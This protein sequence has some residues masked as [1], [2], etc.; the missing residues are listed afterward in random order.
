[1]RLL[2]SEELAVLHRVYEEQGYFIFPSLNDLPIGTVFDRTY[3][4]NRVILPQPFAIV[5]RATAD[6]YV[7]QGKRI[8][9]LEPEMEVYFGPYPFH[10]KAV[11][12]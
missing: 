10:F 3:R 8:I 2:D 4:E 11:T 1:M 6:E 12:E 9:Q 7:A 5:D